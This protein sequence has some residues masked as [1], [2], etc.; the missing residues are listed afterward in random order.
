MHSFNK[1]LMNAYYVSHTI[2]N[3]WNVSVNK[4]WKKISQV[5]QEL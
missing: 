4:H 1:Y 5:N 2:L 3:T